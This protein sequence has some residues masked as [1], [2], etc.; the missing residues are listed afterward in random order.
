MYAYDMYIEHT[1]LITPT[2]AVVVARTLATDMMS[3][4]KK[5]ARRLYLSLHSFFSC[6]NKLTS[7]QLSLVLPPAPSLPSVC[8]Q[9]RDPPSPALTLSNSLQTA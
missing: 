6:R 5:T 4:R 7:S 2:E 8:T 9:P 1:K 3:S